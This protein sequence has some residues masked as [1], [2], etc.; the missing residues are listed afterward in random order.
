MV[1]NG[2]WVEHLIEA[3]HVRDHL[4]VDVCLPV[5]LDELSENIDCTAGLVAEN[6]ARGDVISGNDVGRFVFLCF[7]QF[8]ASL[9]ELTV[10]DV[11]ESSVEAH[12]YS[13]ALRCL[14]DFVLIWHRPH[15][16][17]QEVVD[18]I[19][20]RA[21]RVPIM[22]IEE[23]TDAIKHFLC[24]SSPTRLQAETAGLAEDERRLGEEPDALHDDFV[25]V[26]IIHQASVHA[27][28]LV[29]QHDVLRC[30]VVLRRESAK[31]FV[32]FHLDIF[33]HRP[34]L[35]SIGWRGFGCA[36]VKLAA[37]NHECLLFLQE[38]IENVNVL[39]L[40]QLVQGAS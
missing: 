32:D 11:H 17:V 33:P 40:F 4:F 19:L 21:L 23:R 27:T 7:A 16:T 36:V 20:R 12:E 1:C 24:L 6:L 15:H 29:G 13:D 9:L 2:G 14:V 26:A 30:A 5:V 22:F 35:I 34:G 25:S 39:V 3:H 38:L 10:E 8:G 31:E 37:V 18:L 28:D